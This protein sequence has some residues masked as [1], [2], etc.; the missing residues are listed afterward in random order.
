ME[1]ALSTHRRPRNTQGALCNSSPG[2][3]RA[4]ALDK[5]THAISFHFMLFI[6]CV[7]FHLYLFLCLHFSLLSPILSHPLS[8]YLLFSFTSLSLPCLLFFLCFLLFSSFPSLHFSLSSLPLTPT[9][10]PFSFTCIPGIYS[11]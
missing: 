3:R 1:R 9:P 2:D 8:F 10:S 6:L 5:P 7:T 11:T 4:L